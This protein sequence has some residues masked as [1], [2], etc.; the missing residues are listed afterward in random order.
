M[1][2]I[3]MKKH[4]TRFSAGAVLLAAG[5]L[6]FD[7][8]ATTPP[9]RDQT[10]L[11]YESQQAP[12]EESPQG[13][14][15]GTDQVESHASRGASLYTE[16]QYDR[17]IEELTLA[18][19][20]DS[21]DSVSMAYRG[22]AYRMAS[23][24]SAAIADFD[25]SLKVVPDDTW[26]LSH[27]GETL[28]AMGKYDQA[29]ADLDKVIEREP[30]D[31]WSIASRGDAYRLL[32]NYERAVADFT[33]AVALSPDY[34]WALAR[35]GEAYRM[36]EDNEAALSDLN[37]ALE[38]SSDDT[39]SL[40]SR[41]EV[42]RQLGNYGAALADL[43]RVLALDP[44][45]EWAKDRRQDVID[46]MEGAGPSAGTGDQTSGQAGGPLPVVAVLD[47]RIENI[48]PSDGKLIQ[49][50][51]ASALI[52]T[53]LYRILDRGQQENILREIER[54]LSACNDEK[55]QIEIGRMLSADRILVG[56]LGKVGARYVISAKLLD[57]RSGEALASS[58]QVYKSLE[59]LVEGCGAIVGAL[60]P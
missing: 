59:E 2:G 18:I 60:E 51:L 21:T 28:R 52:Q 27:R 6:F 37:R 58:S 10:G 32:N 47:F 11:G 16:E 43:D 12:V 40:A 14:A 56:S 7:A 33:K 49:D 26:V 36:L 39:F 35:R 57:V 41:G 17:A 55:C 5:L 46:D 31:S 30:E 24:Y 19:A 48:A 38:L 8:C 53:R 22:D 20:E 9:A 42:Y 15:A 44:Q 13:P 23:N 50:L 25:A 45:Y 29:I 1:N 34:Q 3:T 4:F 54:S